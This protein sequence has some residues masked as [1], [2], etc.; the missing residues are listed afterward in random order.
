MKQSFKIQMS[1][2]MSKSWM[3]VRQYGFTL[4]EAMK[5][6]WQVYKLKRCMTKGV[7][8]FIYMKIDG[9][10]RTAWG[11]L[12][13]KYIPHGENNGRKSNDTVTTYWDTEKGAFRCFKTANFIKIA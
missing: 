12:S 4:S 13:E 6:M 10:I 2:L 7:V 9:T 11:T 1:E 8:K 3:L 5:H